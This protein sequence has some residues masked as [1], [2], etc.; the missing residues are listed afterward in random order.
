MVCLAGCA[1]TRNALPTGAVS[2]PRL[3]AQ[4]LIKEQRQGIALLDMRGHRLAWLR[5]F[6]IYPAAPAVQASLDYDFLSTRLNPPLLH[7]PHGW[8]RLDPE[9]HALLPVI[10]N[11]ISLA[12]G[13]TV[14]VRRAEF[15]LQRHGRTVLHAAAPP[16]R[17]LSDQLVQTRTVLYDVADGGRWKLP[18]DG[19]LADRLRGRSVILAC[20]IAH[21]A[22]AASRL[23]LLRLAPDGTTDPLTPPLGELYPER[24]LLSPDQRW[25]A[26]EGDTGCAAS[27]VYVAPAKGGFVHL[28]YG[29][30]IREPFAANYS[31]LLGWSSDDRL[32]VLLEPPYCDGPF[33]PQRPPRGVY[34]VDPRTLARTFVTTRADAMWNPTP[35]R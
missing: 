18:P 30:S 10:G 23:R 12:D 7:G 27:Y 9:R 5:N 13:G 16:F 11:R 32:V 25:I 8:Y 29:R 33:G 2:L 34:L 14:V 26:V 22:E 31:T 3:P 6:T 28:V 17:I 19:C 15:F 35:T 1:A 20:S 4:G 21:G 24:V